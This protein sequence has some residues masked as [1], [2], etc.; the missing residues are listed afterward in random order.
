ME[1][2]PKVN[3]GIVAVSRDCFPI[4]LS[5]RRRKNIVKECGNKKVPVIEI[6]KVV[7]NENDIPDVLNELEKKKVNALIIYLGNFGPE[8]PLSM[9]AQKFKGPVMFVAA[10]EE[11]G[12]DLY[13]GR[14]D[15][16][17]GLLS[18]SY[19]AGLRS[20]KPYIP[21]YPVGRAEEI[22]EMINEFIPVAGILI[23]IGKLKI[24]TFGPRPF[25]FNTLH[26]PIKPLMDMGVEIMENSEL[27]LYEL[28]NNAKDDPEVSGV[29]KDMEQELGK[30]NRYPGVLPKLA[31]YEVALTKFFNENLGTSEFGVFANKCW[32]AFQTSFGFVPCYVN[33]RLA[34]RG[35]PV[36][37]EADVYGALSEYM[38]TCATEAPA[39]ILDVN[40]TVPQDMYNKVKDLA[41]DYA[42]NDLFMGF[43]C[44][45]TCSAC[46]ADYEMKY[47]L[48]MHRLLEPGKDPD[49]TRGT[50]EGRIRAGDITLFRFQSTPENELKAYIAEGEVLDMDPK[51]F[52]GTG[53]IA[54]KE[55][56][57]FYRHVLLEKRFPH[58]AGVGF[59]HAGKALFSASKLLGSDDVSFN[60]PKGIYYPSENPF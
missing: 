22:A 6:N 35:I 47:Q 36:S 7:E 25:D 32:P 3:A 9:L 43:H 37:C 1:N 44:G 38:I 2:L 11:S 20:I 17:C 55:M 50:I 53:I 54:I 59:S 4:E 23:G 41:G 14:G 24:F 60:L 21:E 46:M 8:G 51:T 12:N 16:F 34:S 40:N 52:G 28:Y 33:S 29:L 39:T 42:L 5:E 45:N 27:D 48:I 19:N 58:H 30:G 57:R 15:A 18:A 31:Q 49:I 10:A 13:G 56:G 26:A